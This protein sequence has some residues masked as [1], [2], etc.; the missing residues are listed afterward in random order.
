MNKKDAARH[1]DTLAAYGLLNGARLCLFHR[2]LWLLASMVTN[3]D[4]G[5]ILFDKGIQDRP[6]MKELPRMMQGSVTLL[7]LKIRIRTVLKEKTGCSSMAVSYTH[8]TLPT[9]PYV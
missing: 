6:N 4:V 2:Q 7:I 3:L 9:T 5:F 1:T 8:L